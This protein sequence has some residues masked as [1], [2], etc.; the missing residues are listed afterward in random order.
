[1][2]MLIR[3]PPSLAA[4]DAF[5]DVLVRATGLLPVPPG[6]GDPEGGS[7]AVDGAAGRRVEVV[8]EFRGALVVRD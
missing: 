5:D 2:N 4:A 8:D 3:F 7:L 6:C 1:M